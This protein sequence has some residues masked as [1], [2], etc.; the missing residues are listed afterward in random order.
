M[1][2]HWRA[3]AGVRAIERVCSSVDAG[4]S[5]DLFEVQPRD[6]PHPDF[7]ARATIWRDQA[8]G[9]IS[10]AEA[11]R[12]S[13]AIGAPSASGTPRQGRKDAAPRPRHSRPAPNASRQY[14]NP[15]STTAARDDRLTPQAK[16]L[17]QILRA[18]AGKGRKTVITK[19][20]L[21]AVLS[22]SC[23]SIARYLRDLE[24]FG[25]IV[26]EIRRTGRG[27]HT[28]LV[29]TLSEAVLP[30]FAEAK[31]LSCWL[32]ETAASFMPFA[33]ATPSD[34]RVTKLSPKNQ[35]QKDPFIETKNLALKKVGRQPPIPI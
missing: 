9:L 22:R 33:T 28:G 27:L 13:A 6:V 24:R 18:R 5:L 11:Q 20:T 31:A 1:T 17:L 2:E 32:V 7:V 35:I 12:R 34:H 25:Y 15:M 26:T 23:R 14:A 4:L 8:A 16:A 30:F 19:G 10:L 21:A 29:V 3:P